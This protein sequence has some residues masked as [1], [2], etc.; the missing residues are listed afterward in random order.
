MNKYL[1]KVIP[2]FVVLLVLYLILTPH[3]DVNKYKKIYIENPNP[4]TLFDLCN[5]AAYC[6]N[7][8]D[9]YKYSKEFFDNYG[10]NE[11]EEVYKDISKKEVDEIFDVFLAEFLVKSTKQKHISQE[12]FNEYIFLFRDDAFFVKTLVKYVD[13]YY[14]I[15]SSI[16][17]FLEYLNNSLEVATN[18]TQEM[19]IYVLQIYLYEDLNDDIALEKAINNSKSITQEYYAER[20]SRQL[21]NG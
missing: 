8:S 4:H 19:T 11:I 13:K 18:Y 10:V 15:D 7:Y 5:V 17:I 12:E 3:L 9:F 14:L 2:L 20:Q 1:K 6:Y 21:G 16:K